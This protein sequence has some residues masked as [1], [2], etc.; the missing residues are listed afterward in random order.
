MGGDKIDWEKFERIF[1]SRCEKCKGQD[2][3]LKVEIDSVPLSLPSGMRVACSNCGHAYMLEVQKFVGDEP[4]VK[5][6]IRTPI[7]VWM[8]E[9]AP[10]AFQ[11]RME[12]TP[13]WLAHIPAR[14]AKD[15][16]FYFPTWLERLDSVCEP[17]KVELSDGSL[18]VFGYK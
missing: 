3:Q 6:P 10:L 13:V 7:R 12:D 2:F 18:L 14:T 9:E 17:K 5:N 15:K 16:N 11:E 4:P 1:T 8:G